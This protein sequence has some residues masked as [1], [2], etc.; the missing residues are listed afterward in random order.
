MHC[1]HQVVRVRRGEPGDAFGDIVVD[2]AKARA[3]H[4]EWRKM[5]RSPT[6]ELRCVT[7][8]NFVRE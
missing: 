2:R 4:E 6:G 5:A 7:R 8:S 1:W 3:I